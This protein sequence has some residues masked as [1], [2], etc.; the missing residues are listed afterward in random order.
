MA[1][2]RRCALGIALAILL[3]AWAA[4]T[5]GKEE[6]GVVRLGGRKI[7]EG[8]MRLRGGAKVAT[9]AEDIGNKMS[10]TE[11]WRTKRLVESL[12]NAKG[13]GTSM[14]SLLIKPGDQIHQ[15]A[16]LLQN[17]YGT[18]SNIK[19][20]VNRAS[21]LQAI[22][23]CQTKLKL[24]K[25]IPPNG[26]CV[27]CGNVLDNGKDTHLTIAFEPPRP[28]KSGLYLCD[29][30]FHTEALEEL[31]E[32]DNKFGYI[33]I[34]GTGALFG[35]LNGKSR[36][37]LHSFDVDL[38]KKHGRGG[39]SAP[40][41][42]RIR[43]EKRHAFLAR[44][45]EAAISV[46]ISNNLV[47]V[48]GIILSGPADLK[49][50]LMD[51]DLLDQR[52]KKAVITVVDTAYGGLGGFDEAI[53]LSATLLSDLEV[54]Q[55]QKIMNEIYTEIAKSSKMATSG[56]ENVLSLMDSGAVCSI[57]VWERLLTWRMKFRDKSGEIV[58]RY[59]YREEAKDTKD[60]QLIE[61]SEV[62]EYLANECDN[63]GV[64]VRIVSDQTLEGRQLKEGFGGIVALLRFPMDPDGPT[65]ADVVSDDGDTDTPDIWD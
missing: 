40:R 27:Y 24:F 58:I 9:N 23:S 5:L 48:K 6:R 11:I 44:V 10:T 12:A 62:L 19:S 64:E 17:E 65:N 52:L 39:Q 2:R 47:N 54:A 8:R 22:T 25:T 49:N 38:P 63:N 16:T 18:A 30:R 15:A 20:R 33:V 7:E 59:G 1:A 55:D 53:D 56:V 37:V 34:C 41:F 35:C 36:E 43:L 50:D 32:A 26:L 29:N 13:D 28:L 46:F 60:M 45:A 61:S 14:I 42:N 21:V 4:G 57:V 31:F 3:A 51:G